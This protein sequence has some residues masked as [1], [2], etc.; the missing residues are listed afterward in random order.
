VVDQRSSFEEDDDDENDDVHGDGEDGRTAH[1]A[2]DMAG[3]VRG[4]GRFGL[5]GPASDGFENHIGG[6]GGGFERRQ[7]RGHGQKREQDLVGAPMA[8]LCSTSLVVAATRTTRLWLRY[9]FNWG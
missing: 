8:G 1:F 7:G 2:D 9:F 6:V 4:L 5:A 3:E